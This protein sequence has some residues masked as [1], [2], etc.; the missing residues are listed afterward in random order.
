MASLLLLFLQTAAAAPPADLTIWPEP[1]TVAEVE[2]TDSQGKPR[3]LGDFQGRIVLLNVWATWCA[4][5]REEM[6]T[7]DR[8]QARLGGADFQVLALSVDPDGEQLVR[9]FYADIGIQHLALY[10]DETAQANRSLGAYGLPATLLLDRQGRE[11]GRKLGAAEWD[12]P[13]VIDYL[14][15]LMATPQGH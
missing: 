9:D 2:F 6:P 1:K 14:R 5:C 15:E 10:I 4:P 13:E 3:T 11:L 12:S 7:L 8:L